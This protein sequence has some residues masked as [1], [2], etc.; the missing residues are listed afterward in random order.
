MT[1]FNIALLLNAVANILSAVANL[2]TALRRK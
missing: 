2:T 1:I